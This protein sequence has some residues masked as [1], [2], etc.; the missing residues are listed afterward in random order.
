[1]SSHVGVLYI[2]E[3]GLFAATKNGIIDANGIEAAVGA[4]RA[5]HANDEVQRL[6]KTL[7]KD[8]GFV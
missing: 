2:Q 5:H 7:L 4:M 3:C 8:I 6:G 1:M